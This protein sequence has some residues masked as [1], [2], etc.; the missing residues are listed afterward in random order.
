M[1]RTRPKE[2]SRSLQPVSLLSSHSQPFSPA[3]V[4]GR[5]NETEGT[6]SG[7]TTT[8][9]DVRVPIS[10]SF[11]S[12][13]TTA[14]RAPCCV[15]HGEAPIDIQCSR[16]MRRP[17]GQPVRFFCLVRTTTAI[18]PARFSHLCPIVLRAHPSPPLPNPIPSNDDR[19]TNHSL[20]P[21]T[22][23]SNSEALA[24]PKTPTT[25]CTFLTLKRLPFMAAHSNVQA[26]KEPRWTPPE[27]PGL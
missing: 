2:S 5:K 6:T 25:T 16:S 9:N 12:D 19:S 21:V 8:E 11:R 7:E 3:R 18:R 4:P 26:W 15:Y 1:R 14:L 13:F 24:M 27:H 22:P 23:L 17:R 20:E 10:I